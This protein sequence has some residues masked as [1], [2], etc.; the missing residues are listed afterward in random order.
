MDERDMYGFTLRKFVGGEREG[1][2]ETFGLGGR[3]K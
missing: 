3:R 2:R 1:Q